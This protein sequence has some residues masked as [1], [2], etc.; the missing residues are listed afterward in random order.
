M[1]SGNDPLHRSP[2][3]LHDDTKNIRKQSVKNY[4]RCVDQS[5]FLTRFRTEFTSLVW[6]FCCWGT[7]VPPSKTSLAERSK[8]KGLYSQATEIPVEN[9]MVRAILFGKLQKIWA[10]ISG[11]AIFLLFLVCSADLD[12]SRLFSYHLKYYSFLFMHQISSWVVCKNQNGKHPRYFLYNY[13]Q[14]NCQSKCFFQGL[15]QS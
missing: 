15:G 13:N 2:R 14:T 11:N 1:L 12:N 3:A 9:Q 10:V 5:E 7:G 6:N 4:N 8:E